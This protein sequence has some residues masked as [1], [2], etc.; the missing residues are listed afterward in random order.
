MDSLIAGGANS[1]PLLETT[2]ENDES[3]TDAVLRAT[4]TASG[5]SPIELPPLYDAIEPD[6]L[7]SLFS[8]RDGGGTIRF[9]YH[10]F[11]VVVHG[12]ETIELYEQ[13]PTA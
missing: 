1:T 11:T 13:S 4:A 8:D 2:I 12:D 3:A 9:G 7:D 6:G 5:A 10:E